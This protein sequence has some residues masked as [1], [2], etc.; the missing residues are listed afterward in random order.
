MATRPCSDRDSN[1]DTL[2]TAGARVRQAAIFRTCMTDG[3]HFRTEMKI[4]NPAET[5]YETQTG[6]PRVNSDAPA[7]L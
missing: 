5:S 3:R 7:W 4:A 2:S 1:P 6:A